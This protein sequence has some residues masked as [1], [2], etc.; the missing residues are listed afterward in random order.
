MP[1]PTPGG[2]SMYPGM[3]SQM[4]QSAM[5]QPAMPLAMPSGML[6]FKQYKKSNPFGPL[7]QLD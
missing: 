2:S 5:P 3:P 1:M 7:F 6:W 4:P